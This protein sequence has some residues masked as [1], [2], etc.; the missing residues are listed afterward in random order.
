MAALSWLVPLLLLAVAGW[1]IW[2]QELDIA[3]ARALSALRVLAEE[4]EKVFE[5]QEMALD[6]IDDRVGNQGWD[7]IENSAEL[8]DF[9]VD[10]N[11]KSNYIDSIWLF[12]ARGDVRATTRAF[13][14]ERRIN[15]ADRDYF[16]S[17]ERDG[18]GI[19]IGM[20]AAGRMT[21]TFAFHV[22]VRRSTSNGSFDGVI[23]LALSPK[24]F[25]KSFLSV[26]NG[27]GPTVMLMRP[28]GVILA[29]S[30]GPSPGSVLP[31]DNPY[32]ARIRGDSAATDVFR[33]AC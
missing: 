15:V 17:A 24:Y 1:Q 19:H 26:T 14:L 11:K 28:D 31:S 6:W 4:A 21:G 23:L 13:P 5:A 12:D 33:N 18:H 20:P 22:A 7:E 10:L 8:H 25:E 16:R 27:H 30:N 29:S 3:E 9:L 2:E 32:L